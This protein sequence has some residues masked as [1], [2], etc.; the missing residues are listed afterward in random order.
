ML[1]AG[2]CV[3]VCMYVNVCV[4]ACVCVCVYV[5]VYVCVCV[6]VH[7]CVVSVCVCAWV[8][9]L[10]CTIIFS[11]SRQAPHVDPLV[12]CSHWR[13]WQ[14]FEGML[15][16]RCW[17][18]PLPG[19]VTFIGV[20]KLLQQTPLLVAPTVGIGNASKVL[21]NNTDWVT[22]LSIHL[23]LNVRY[24]VGDCPQQFLGVMACID[25]VG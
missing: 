21:L 12:R 14:C 10:A 25:S 17:L 7:V 1:F 22:S 19:F 6:R 13:D 24:G 23:L 2:A 4:C 11:G 18:Y 9:H 8:R 16:T 3:C 15:D 5:C 20:L